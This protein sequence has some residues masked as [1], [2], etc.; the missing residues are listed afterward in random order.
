MNH[1]QP[2]RCYLIENNLVESVTFIKT[3]RIDPWVLI[4][5][6]YN[7]DNQNHVFMLN[8]NFYT[9]GGLKYRLNQLTT[10]RI[11]KVLKQKI[12]IKH[13]CGNVSIK[14]IHTLN[15]SLD[16]N[17]CL[18]Y[19]GIQTTTKKNTQYKLSQLCTKVFRGPG[20]YNNEICKLPGSDNYY[21]IGHTA[22][23]ENGFDSKNLT[24]IPKNLFLEHE[25]NYAVYPGD[26][27]MLSR[28]TTNRVVL[29]PTNENKNYLANINLS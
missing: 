22:L 28:A 2:L 3:S 26:I 16:P 25:E 5:L 23:T 1:L 4:C 12:H 27:V 6:S 21:M 10:A 29:I 15:Y 20:L 18:S 14:T 7:P 8:E 11:I 13:L 17:A 24:P 19:T 9:S